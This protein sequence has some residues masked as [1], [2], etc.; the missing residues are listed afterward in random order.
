MKDALYTFDFAILDWISDTLVY[1]LLDPIFA[2]ITFLGDAGW[3]WIALTVLCLCFRKTRRIGISMAIS[4]VFSL[5]VTNLTLKPLVNRPRPYEL[6]E[7]SLRV[8]PP[9]DASFPSGHSSASFAAA[10]ALFWEDKKR[11]IPALVLATLIAF[12]RLYFYLHFFTDVLGGSL[13]GFWGSLIAHALTPFV[14]KGLDRL[15]QKLK[16]KNRS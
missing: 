2:F 12:S 6:R 16:N 4:L 9:H 5:L 8:E 14:L 3:F 15:Y 1:P 13:V 10:F 7:I 11:G